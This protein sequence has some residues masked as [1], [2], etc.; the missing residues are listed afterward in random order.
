MLGYYS[1]LV[2]PVLV[3]LNIQTLMATLSRIRLKGVVNK[4]FKVLLDTN[5]DT[6]SL[7]ISQA[8]QRTSRNL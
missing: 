8:I 3:K 5:E 6:C 7:T 1:L 2:T 4:E